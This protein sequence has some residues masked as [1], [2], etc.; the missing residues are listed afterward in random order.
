MNDLV[1]EW[2]E[3]AEGDYRTAERESIV[4]EGPNWDAVFPCTAG[5]REVRQGPS[6]AGRH[7]HSWIARSSGPC[8]SAPYRSRGLGIRGR[9][10]GEAVRFCSRASLSW[11]S[12]YQEGCSGSRSHYARVAKA[13]AEC[14]GN[15]RVGRPIR[16]GIQRRRIGSTVHWPFLAARHGSCCQ[17]AEEQC[18]FLPPAHSRQLSPILPIRNFPFT[19]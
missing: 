1:R 12:R 9:V 7:S 16:R 19:F 11:G 3:K 17:T 14:V 6:A 10:L 2:V 5:C 18:L 13:L 4:T 8:R 15:W